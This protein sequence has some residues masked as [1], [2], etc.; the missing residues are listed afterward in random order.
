MVVNVEQDSGGVEVT[1]LDTAGRPHTIRTK[2]A[3]LAPGKFLTQH[4]IPDLDAEHRNAFSKFRY[5][6]YLVGEVCTK[7]TVFNLG[8]DNW[9]YDEPAFVDFTVADWITNAGEGSPGRPNVLS[10]YAPK[11]EEE[12][13]ELRTRSFESYASE[14]VAGLSKVIPDSTFQTKI[15]EIRLYRWGHP[16]LIPYPSFIMGLRRAAQTPQG[17]LIFANGDSEGL[18]CVEAAFSAGIRGGQEAKLLCQ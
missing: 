13:A 3:V 5:A 8:Y 2:A 17:R 1:Y 6:A 11:S 7:S 15:T 16:M 18:P 12:R 9:V 14:I 4:I 10:I